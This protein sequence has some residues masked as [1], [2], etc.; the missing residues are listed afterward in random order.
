MAGSVNQIFGIIRVLGKDYALQFT[1]IQKMTNSHMLMK[2]VG[3]LSSAH[4]LQQAPVL[5]STAFHSLA[6]VNTDG[7]KGRV[8]RSWG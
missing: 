3:V 1:S 6:T 4:S 2:G 7:G 8:I 5:S